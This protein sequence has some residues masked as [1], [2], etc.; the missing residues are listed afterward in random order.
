MKQL[1]ELA[2][3][4]EEHNLLKKLTDKD[5][6]LDILDLT[7]DSRQARDGSLF[8]CK[9]QAFKPAYLDMAM[10]LGASA[11]VSEID[12]DVNIPGL[13]VSD[14]RKAMLVL[15]KYFF[16]QPD[17][18]LKIVGIT[19]T[20]GKTTTVKFLK[21]ILDADL[22]S[23]GKKPA[24]LISTVNVYDGMQDVSAKLTT[25]EAI[26]LYRYLDNAVKSGLSHMIIEVSSQ[27]LK[28]DRVTNVSF[29]IGA[30]L[31]IGQDHVS[32]FEHP[33]HQ[34]YF[35]SKLTLANLSKEFIYNLDMDQVDQVEAYLSQHKIPANSYSLNN[36]N[37]DL[38]AQNIQRKGYA[39]HFDLFVNG[40]LTSFQLNY[41]GD[42]NIENAIVALM[43]AS[44]LGASTRSMQIGLR[45]AVVEGRDNLYLTDDEKILAWVSYAHNGL[46]F[47]KSYD[48]INEN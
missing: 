15:A 26:T 23:R 18:K 46:S 32:E 41:P 4:L 47:Q 30:F 43:I 16:D 25:P 11:Y 19:A 33:S 34:D 10:D 29:D 13:I 40:Q 31:N 35:Q 2:N 48:V 9:G 24:G 45:E 39:N 22:K 12:Y 21:S 7:Y 20:K 1:K 28:Y 6:D 3:V 14:I 42:Y 37:A 38:Y 36:T 8:F 27:A 17:E 5:L 44:M